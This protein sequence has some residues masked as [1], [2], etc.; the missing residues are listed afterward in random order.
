MKHSK[1]EE[2]RELVL[3]ERNLKYDNQEQRWTANYPWIKDPA[4]LPDNRKAAMRMLISTEKRLEKNHEN[5]KVYQEQIED[6]VVR[7]VARKLS[8]D[9]LYAYSMLTSTLYRSS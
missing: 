4:D 6:M 7:N 2:E 8:K 1:S 3:I 5:A 9:E